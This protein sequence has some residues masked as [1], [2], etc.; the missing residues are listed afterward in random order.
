MGLELLK[1]GKKMIWIKII[2]FLAF[3]IVSG[4]VITIAVLKSK[5]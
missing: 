2:L 4:T 3:V 1:R 5:E